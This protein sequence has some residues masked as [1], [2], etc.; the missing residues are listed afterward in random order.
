MPPYEDDTILTQIASM[1]SRMASLKAAALGH[2]DAD[3][4][5]NRLEKIDREMQALAELLNRGNGNIKSVLVNGRQHAQTNGN[6][7]SCTD[8]NTP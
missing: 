8:N 1:R 7:R 4:V 3:F 2:A 5:C 6:G